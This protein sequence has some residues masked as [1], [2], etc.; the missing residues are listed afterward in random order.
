MSNDVRVRPWQLVL[1]SIAGGAVGAFVLALL[2]PAPLES[3]MQALVPSFAPL[4]KQVMPAV[5]NI[6]TTKTAVARG[7]RRPFPRG[8]DPFEQFFGEDFW[9]RF[10]GR[11]GPQKQRSLG[12]GFVID[13]DGS[14]ITNHHVVDGADDIDVQFANGKQ[15]KA[16]VIGSDANVSAAPNVTVTQKSTRGRA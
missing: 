5:V 1:V 16:K 11:R 10:G 4:A 15:Y 2:Q 3:Q 8:Q 13:E 12:S 7:P 6:N 14:I 9:E